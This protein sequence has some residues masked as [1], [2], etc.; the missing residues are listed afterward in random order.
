M[1]SS[2]KPN[3]LTVETNIQ[4][5]TLSISFLSYFYSLTEICVTNLPIHARTLFIL[6]HAKFHCRLSFKSKI[7][8]ELRMNGNAPQSKHAVRLNGTRCK[9]IAKKRVREMTKLC[10]WTQIYCANIL[11]AINFKR[12][13]L[14]FIEPTSFS[15]VSF[16]R[17]SCTGNDVCVCVSV[18]IWLWLLVLVYLCVA[19]DYMCARTGMEGGLLQ[20]REAERKWKL[21]H[22]FTFHIFFRSLELG[23]TNVNF[24]IQYYLTLSPR[25]L[26]RTLNKLDEKHVY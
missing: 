16:E 1:K 5:K 6:P 10:A 20:A 2:A 25:T 19:L 8:N 12:R 21:T 17:L 11:V 9:G 14:T 26:A 23:D 22:N 7:L 15:V 4:L 18:R 24:S 13:N 3:H